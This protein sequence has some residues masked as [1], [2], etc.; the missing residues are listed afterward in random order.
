[1]LDTSSRFLCVIGEPDVTHVRFVKWVEQ[2]VPVIETLNVSSLQQS[3]E[4]IGQIRSPETRRIVV[5]CVGLPN[6]EALTK[7]SSTVERI[8]KDLKHKLILCETLFTNPRSDPH[9][10][11]EHLLNT[12]FIPPYTMTY[13]KSIMSPGYLPAFIYKLAFAIL[14][15]TQIGETDAA[16][17]LEANPPDWRVLFTQLRVPI[18]GASFHTKTD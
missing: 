18:N 10:G 8:I 7:V 14:S 4:L 16:A 12:L 6:Q 3:A 1:M 17:L 9:L 13:P 2:A 11:A 5:Y 15:G